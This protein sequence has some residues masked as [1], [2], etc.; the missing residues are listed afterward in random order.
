MS[1]SLSPTSKHLLVGLTQR[2]R[3]PPDGPADRPLMAQVTI[4]AILILLGKCLLGKNKNDG[5]G[6]KNENAGEGIRNKQGQTKL[7]RV[8]PDIRPFLISGIRP[9][10]LL[11]YPSH[12]WPVFRSIFQIALRGGKTKW[13]HPQQKVLQGE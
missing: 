2:T 9:D 10:I 1:V 11:D 6:R 4:Y 12:S 13:L 7:T 5:A 3:M 8:V